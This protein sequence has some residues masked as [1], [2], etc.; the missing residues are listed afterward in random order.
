MQLDECCCPCLLLSL[1]T[2][3][4]LSAVRLTVCLSV[5][6][7]CPSQL[8]SPTDSPYLACLPSFLKRWQHS[9][10]ASR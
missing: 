4:H 1:S 10:I 7:C 3:V 8:F 2:T 6:L 5:C 9:V